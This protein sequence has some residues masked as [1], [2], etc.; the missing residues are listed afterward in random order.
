[1]RLDSLMI[2]L[3]VRSIQDFLD[4]WSLAALIKPSDLER[5]C[6]ICISCSK[7]LSYR[8]HLSINEGIPDDQL[9]MLHV[10]GTARHLIH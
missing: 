4:E 10:L 1:M 5:L 3:S 7:V 8:T 6:D 9:L 2:A